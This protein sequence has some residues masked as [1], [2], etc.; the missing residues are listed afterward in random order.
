MTLTEKFNAAIARGRE[1]DPPFES[2]ETDDT[3][4]LRKVANCHT[5]RAP[6]SNLRD[7]QAARR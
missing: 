6:G 2:F 3:P 4:L 1:L 7:S 5:L